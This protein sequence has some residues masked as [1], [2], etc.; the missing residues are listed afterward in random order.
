MTNK[1]N[2]KRAFRV[3]HASENISLEE[4]MN[5]EKVFKPTRKLLS[6]CICAALICAL[7]VTA[8]AYGGEVISRIFG[9]GNNF[10]ISQ[11]I[12]ENGEEVSVSILYTERLT[13]PVVIQDGRMIFIVN[14][15]S[16]DISDQ[17]S[18]SEA[19]RYDYTDEKGNTHFW[20]VGLNSDDINNYGYAEYI[21]DPHGEW[22]G[23]YHARVNTEADGS[24]SAQW[25]E[26]AKSAWNI[27]W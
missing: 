25:L 6:V 27:P 9:W 16:M 24:T 12:D 19:F 21:K 8:Y 4:N 23:G 5:R 10:E 1:E 15:E 13:D 11:S 14:N 17:V 20:C 26:S 3:L 7:G 22:A 2:Y 18:E